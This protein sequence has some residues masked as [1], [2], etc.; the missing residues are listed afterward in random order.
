[1][2]TKYIG[3][4]AML[5]CAAAQDHALLPGVD[6]MSRGFD[7][8]KGTQN[9]STAGEVLLPL[10]QWAY[11]Q[12]A[13]FNPPGS[14][15]TY[16]VPDQVVP[17][18]LD[19]SAERIDEA[20]IETFDMWISEKLDSFHVS[21]GVTIG[22]GTAAMSMNAAYNHESYVYEQEMKAHIGASGYSYHWMSLFQLQGLPPFLM[23]LA[24]AF[25]V[26]LQRLP[27]SISSP[28]DQAMYNQ[29]VEYWGTHYPVLANFGGKVTVNTFV[30]QSLFEKHTASWVYNQ[31]SLE[32][33]MSLFNISGGGF[34]NK[35]SIHI[36]QQFTENSHTY[37]FFE[38]GDPRLQ[39]N[40]TCGQW[41]QSVP[42]YP[43]YLNVT[44][45]D[46]STAIAPQDPTK[47][48]LLQKT[49]QAY[50]K[51]GH[52]PATDGSIED[53]D[54]FYASLGPVPEITSLPVE[55][56]QA[57]QAHGLRGSSKA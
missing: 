37:V 23:Q 42:D 35:S 17:T 16:S 57:Q 14:T 4:L 45:A 13:T 21:A 31:L 41:L 32:F 55:W 56:M 49:I 15:N 26:A 11:T 38:G 24:P 28:A 48:A 50:I 22:N 12:G 7:M 27:S 9:G 25:N 34:Q 33:H 44:I 5:A 47:A 8:V 30:N 29:V 39:S 19:Q 43:V 2:F 10:W 46:I 6:I 53:Y 3:I 18:G 40:E 1:M 52:L 36:D 54:A 20:L 51:S